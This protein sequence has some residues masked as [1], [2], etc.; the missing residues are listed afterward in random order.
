MATVA[1]ALT[2]GA[3]GASC[4]NQDN[5]KDVLRRDAGPL[6]DAILVAHDYS[7]GSY[8]LEV[9]I[10][11]KNSS[12]ESG[13]VP[14]VSIEPPSKPDFSEDLAVRWMDSHTLKV[15]YLGSVEDS[16]NFADN[17]DDT[18]PIRVLLHKMLNRRA[19]P[20]QTKK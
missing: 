8:A 6:A 2:L 10:V 5:G 1:V 4:D 12:L 13:L 16:K 20:D 18:K 7:P 11:P 14:V 9:Y 15:D 3:I 17:I 19:S